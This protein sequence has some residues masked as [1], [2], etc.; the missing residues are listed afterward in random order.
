MHKILRV[1]EQTSESR[2]FDNV[3]HFEG[4]L[5]GRRIKTLNLANLILCQSALCNI[6]AHPRGHD[7]HER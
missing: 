7:W 4:L 3:E 2:R 5:H 6:T 1:I